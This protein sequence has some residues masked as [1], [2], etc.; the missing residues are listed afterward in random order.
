MD[1]EGTALERKEDDGTTPDTDD[2]ET[3]TGLH[4]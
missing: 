2:D 4:T 1:D 3:A